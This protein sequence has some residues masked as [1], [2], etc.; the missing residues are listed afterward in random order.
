MCEVAN[1]LCENQITGVPV[2]DERKKYVGVISLSD[3]VQ[4]KAEEWETAT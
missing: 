4:S 1:I 3:F 2:V